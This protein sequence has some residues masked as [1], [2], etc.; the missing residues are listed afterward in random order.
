MTESGKIPITIGIVGHLDA[1][2]KHKHKLKIE[3]GNWYLIL[4]EKEPGIEGI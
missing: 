4:K 3:N 1:I 2:T